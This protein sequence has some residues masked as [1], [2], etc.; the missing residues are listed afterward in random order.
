MEN[1]SFPRYVSLNTKTVVLGI[2]G[3]VMCLFALLFIP[4][5]FFVGA[6]LAGVEWFAVILSLTLT[7][8]G[9]A[10]FCLCNRAVYR[11]FSYYN[12]KLKNKFLAYIFYLICPIP[13]LELKWLFSDSID[14]VEE[15]SAFLRR[16]SGNRISLMFSLLMFFDNTEIDVNKLAELIR[17]KSN[18]FATTRDDE[19]ILIASNIGI[20]VCSLSKNG[21]LYMFTEVKPSQQPFSFSSDWKL[22]YA[23]DMSSAAVY[24]KEIDPLSDI[25]LLSDTIIT[26]IDNLLNKEIERTT[27]K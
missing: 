6:P 9:I 17:N 10:G 19:D 23:Q 24:E 22:E 20:V 13:L 4:T 1:T 2:L 27:K 15:V 25:E 7:T 16:N 21:K 8:G 14:R 11:L 12:R 3:K 18:Y 26:A 5:W